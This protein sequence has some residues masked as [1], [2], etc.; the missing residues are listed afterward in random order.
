MQILPVLL[1]CA[2]FKCVSTVVA[3]V[4][5]TDAACVADS[6]VAV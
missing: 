2:V 4:G 1:S 5:L 3:D 6:D